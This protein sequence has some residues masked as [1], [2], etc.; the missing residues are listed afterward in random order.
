MLRVLATAAVAIACIDAQPRVN[1]GGV[2]NAASYA[3]DGAS[4]D[5]IPR[6]GI[7][8][9]FGEN[10]GPQ[11]LQVVKE[12]PLQ[13]ILPSGNGTS[14]RVT[15]GGASIECLMI[16]TSARQVAAILP[17]ATPAG[18]G[19][20][21]VTY[22][23]QTSNEVNVKIVDR[24]FGIFTQ[25]ST[26]S[27]Q[28]SVQNFLS[29]TNTPLNT[30]W[31]SAK[32]ES[33]VTLW[34][35]G[36]GPVTWDES[37]PPHVADFSGVDVRVWV[38]SQE[39]RIY[40]KGRSGCCAGI[41]QIIFYVPKGMEGCQV[42]VA[43]QIGD[44]VSNFGTI[45]ISQEGGQCPE[46]AN[47]PIAVNPPSG[48]TT[49]GSARMGT[50]VLIRSRS[51]FVG[52]SGAQESGA[53]DS[54]GAG[55]TT[56]P[57]APGMIPVMQS[58]SGSPAL[59]LMY[60]VGGCMVLMVS[61]SAASV[62]EPASTKGTSVSVGSAAAVGGLD[63][64]DH[65]L[66]KGPAGSKEI[67]RTM[68]FDTWFPQ[69]FYSRSFGPLDTVTMQPSPPFVVT[70]T[71]TVSAPGGTGEGAVGPF[72]FDVTI[73]SEVVW[74]NKDLVG[75]ITR[76]RGQ[77]ITWEGGDP[78]GIVVISGMSTSLGGSMIGMLSCYE[79]VSA[80]RFTIPAYV[81]LAMPPGETWPFLAWPFLGVTS[82][83]QLR[84]FTSPGLDLGTVTGT[85]SSA[86]VLAYR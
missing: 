24:S 80:G 62:A 22:N 43:V 31:T 2:L 55:F 84:T 70:G 82:M 39:A 38:G 20:L 75:P 7:L 61:T 32:P 67:P 83:T 54:V 17:S 44:R 34:G 21:R 59:S 30:M 42:P 9:V 64:G 6:G 36:L 65:L 68:L 63:A 48:A 4:S 86:K 53:Q 11:I 35:T 71:Y 58:I 47:L 45:S 5:G 25:T 50:V 33:V 37:G 14:V 1:P 40:Y 28:A 69:G 81:L 76:S 85:S 26:G 51:S 57:V 66:V 10:L 13:Q 15:S 23:G 3:V 74:T 73:P 16:Y 46:L 78:E 72:S 77:L 12:F 41:D 19:K 60:P 27:G 49:T 79:R 56:V 18:T 52:L 29:E 8:V